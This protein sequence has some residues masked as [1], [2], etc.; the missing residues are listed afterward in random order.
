MLEA[1]R[2]GAQG[3]VAKFLFA[4]LILSFAVWGIGDMFTGFTRGSVAKVGH[5]D[6]P[7]EDFQRAFRQELDELSKQFGQTLTAEQARQFGLDSRVISQLIGSAAVESHAE[8]LKF[9]LS[10]DAIVDITHRD[11]AF[12]DNGKFSRMRFE[13]WLAQSGFGERGYIIR[14]RQDELRNQVLG[15][16]IA[17]LNIPK[18][19]IDLE[20]AYRDEKRVIAHLTI[21]EDKAVKVADPD[22]VKLKAT[23]DS[24][25]KQFTTPEYRKLAILTLAMDDVKK[26][27][28]ITD[29]E[30]S[31]SY[32]V[33]KSEYDIPERRRVQQIAFKDKASAE[34]GK[35]ALDEGKTFGEV[36]TSAGAKDTDVDLGLVEKTQLIDPKVRDVAFS[37]EKDKISNVVEGRFASVVLRVVQI[38][39]A[40]TK[41]LADVKG[42]V[43]DKLAADKANEEIQK[44]HDDVEDNR[45]AGKTLKEIAGSLKL[46]FFEAD[47]DSK[48]VAPDGSPA[49]ANI[50][51]VRIAEAGFAGES[52]LE[53]EAI[54]L[55]DGSF[56]WVDVL[57]VT[58]PKQKAFE[59]VKND[60]KQLY[61]TT[62]RTRL[63]TELAKEM[64]ERINKGEP[65]TAL[66]A[67][68]GNTIEKTEAITRKVTPQGLTEAG[69]Q[70]AFRLGVGKAT[71]AETSDKQSRT[72]IT[73]T[74][75]IP[76]KPATP[77]QVTAIRKE[78]ETAMA[79]EQLAAYVEA[80]QK[81]YGVS[82]N[83]SEIKRALGVSDT[84]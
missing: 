25:I 38:E 17:G 24:N 50:E 4:I 63:V 75:I 12:K 28:P 10:D 3:W 74:E 73:A 11:E 51:A 40:V 16:Y 79:Q 20:H 14:R 42:T 29:D 70:Q 33:T 5:K 15:S 84:Q 72:I 26:R 71:T 21:D 67:Q 76:A 49:I 8:D 41:T 34:A 30:I 43:R 60:V 46:T 82:M 55:A 9:G 1:L 68:A 47:T 53:H 13:N 48:G 37:L 35:K 78:L 57:G 36:A 23:Y 44:L 56:V 52:G 22:D 83:D 61:L 45:G 59:Q 80:V 31:A 54:D 19:V 69:V 66:E 18:T 27:V 65:L 64:A 39:P 81:R 32:E 77:E 2:R 7:V 6:I 62:E 58:E